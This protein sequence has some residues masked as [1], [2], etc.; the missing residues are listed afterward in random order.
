M[1]DHQLSRDEWVDPG[2]IALHL[3][4]RVAHRRQVDDRRHAGEVLHQNAGGG[5]RDLLA[6][7]GLGVPSGERLDILGPDRLAVLVSQ[8]V[9]EQDLERERQAGD[10]VLRLQRIQ[11]EY[12][13]RAVVHRQRGPR[14]E[15]VG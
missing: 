9:L 15:A 13:V 14:V 7:F 6:R 10:V 8:Q 1:V 12:L 2:R 3:D 4:H 11:A 5:E